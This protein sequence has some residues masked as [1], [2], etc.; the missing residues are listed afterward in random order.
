MPSADVT[1]C[2]HL[3]AQPVDR[4]WPDEVDTA[5]VVDVDRVTGR[6]RTDPRTST[7][8]T[9]SL[10]SFR[11]RCETTSS[12]TVRY[13]LNR[14]SGSTRFT[15]AEG[16]PHDDRSDHSDGEGGGNDVGHSHRSYMFGSGDKGQASGS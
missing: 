11:V 7:S 15:S 6:R 14:R 16:S 2:I 12:L 13:P 3:G 4:W 5:T 10:F 1:V 8:V 9:D